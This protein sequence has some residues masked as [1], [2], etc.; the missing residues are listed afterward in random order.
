MTVDIA[1][2]LEIQI[3]SVCFDFKSGSWS[4]SYARRAFGMEKTESFCFDRATFD[5]INGTPEQ[6]VDALSQRLRASIVKKTVL[7]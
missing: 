1:E 3:H 7:P 4:V 2:N 5:L 6:I